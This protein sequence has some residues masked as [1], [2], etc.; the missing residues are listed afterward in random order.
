[1][2]NFISPE[3]AY[4]KALGSLKYYESQGKVDIDDFDTWT[5][6]LLHEFGLHTMLLKGVELEVR[7]GVATLPIDYIVRDGALYMESVWLCHRESEPSIINR[8]VLSKEW[9]YYLE[10]KTENLKPSNDVMF[11]CD[12]DD[13]KVT[14]RIYFNDVFFKD[15]FFKD[16]LVKYKNRL[17]QKK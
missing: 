1:M 7:K 12:S 10:T 16:G 9:T 17:Q 5:L 6:E 13:V 11:N 2:D 4:S 3:F 15:S 8:T 14:R